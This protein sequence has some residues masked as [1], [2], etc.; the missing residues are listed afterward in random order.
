MGLTRRDLLR[1][2]LGAGAFLAAS[3]TGALAEVLGPSSFS[4]SRRSRLFPEGTRLVHADLHNHSHLSDG[5]GDP[6]LAYSSMRSGGLDVAAL[7]DHSTVSWGDPGVVDATCAAIDGE[8]QHGE[9]QDCR[10]VAGLDEERWAYARELADAA[11]DPGRFTAIRGF[12]WSSPFLGHINV[13][14]SQRWIDPLHT[15]GIDSSGLGEHFREVPGVGDPVG[16][17]IDDV[18]YANPAHTGMVPFYEWLAA[19]PSTPAVGGGAD[20]IAGFNHPGRE[21]GRFSYFRYHPAAADRIVSMEILNRRDDYLFQ[22]Y[23]DG[24]P[25]P[26]VQCLNAGWRVGLLGVTDEHGPDWGYPDGKGRTGL[27]VT[28]LSRGGVREALVAHRAFATFLRG[29]RVDASARSLT[30]TRDDS[31]PRG[32]GARVRMGQVLPHDRGPVVFELD[33]DRGTEWWGKALQ[34]QVLRPGE[35]VPTVAH[36]EDVRVPSDDEPVISF[37]VPLDASGG[38]W[39]V[40]RIADP[41]SR[42]DQQGPSGHP[43]N[44]GAVAYTSPFWLDPDA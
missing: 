42:N 22:S 9:R 38:D 44:L 11:D 28:E 6:S 43:A 19:D 30:D 14:F 18:G 35:E 7:T 32:A 33:I 10:S 8:P 5:A 23:D 16:Q 26:L 15:A 25:S 21:T 13:W 2:G 17:R 40:L 31:A 3:P 12:E 24:Q 20:G 36:V 4:T 34:V 39:V 37:Q 27:W 41:A 1:A 29:L